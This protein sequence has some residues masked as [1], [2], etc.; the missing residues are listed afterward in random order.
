VFLYALLN[1]Q[2]T[3]CRNFGQI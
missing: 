2:L 3:F 1:T